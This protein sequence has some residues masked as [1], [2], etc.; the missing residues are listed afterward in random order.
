M[1]RD[2]ILQVLSDRIDALDSGTRSQVAEEF[3]MYMR[4]H[5]PEEWAAFTYGIEVSHIQAEVGG[6]LHLPD[7]VRPQIDQ[8]LPRRDPPPD[9]GSPKLRMDP[10]DPNATAIVMRDPGNSLDERMEAARNLKDWIIKGGVPQDLPALDPD[11]DPRAA[12]LAECDWN[13]TMLPV[14]ATRSR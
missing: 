5:H 9:A 6:G 3:V 13:L 12:A 7:A 10:M 11:D 4:A 2:K 14:E 1:N 8:E